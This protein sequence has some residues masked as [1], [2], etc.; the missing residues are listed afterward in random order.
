MSANVEIQ[1]ETAQSRSSGVLPFSVL[2]GLALFIGVICEFGSPGSSIAIPTGLLMLLLGM[3]CHRSGIAVWSLWLAPI[4]LLTWLAVLIQPSLLALTLHWFSLFSL[5]LAATTGKPP[6]IANLQCIVAATVSLL[7]GP[8]SLVNSPQIKLGL[9]GLLAR[10]PG[11]LAL[12]NLVLPVAAFGLFATLLVIANPMMESLLKGR[13]DRVLTGYSLP[14]ALAALVLVAA[15]SSARM[16]G[17]HPAFDRP[18]PD[19][20]WRSIFLNPVSLTTTLVLLNGLFAVQNLFDFKYVWLNGELPPG[21][22]HAEYVHRGSYSLIATAM[23]AALLIVFALRRHSATE[24][25]PRVRS[26]VYLWILQNVLLVASS[27]ARTL[28]YV[29][30]YGM[31][32]WRLSGLIWMGIVAAGLVLVAIRVLARRGNEWLTNANLAVCFA[33]LLGCSFVDLKWIVAEWNVSRKLAEPAAPFDLAYLKSLG[34]SALPALIRLDQSGLANT[35][36]PCTPSPSQLFQPTPVVEITAPLRQQQS[37]W[38]TYSLLDAHYEAQL[39]AH[40]ASCSGRAV[41]DR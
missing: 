5:A 23:L 34:P 14:A 33:V 17:W 40:V 39:E 25:S 10:H 15:I 1:A 4:A 24:A 6:A 29:N 20:H 12:T 13:F 8:L 2:A 21:L 32:M 11:M 30:D 27:A 35:V 19:T 9:K 7:T 28:A 26:L 22:T 18:L 16:A 31:S 36:M 3:A 41:L 38:Q 37:R